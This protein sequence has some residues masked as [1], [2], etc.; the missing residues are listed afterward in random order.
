M[1]VFVWACGLMFWVCFDIISPWH[2][3]SLSQIR[4]IVK[5]SVYSPDTW[6]NCNPTILLFIV[7]KNTTYPQRPQI[8]HAWKSYYMLLCGNKLSFCY[9]MFRAHEN[10]NFSVS[11]LHKIFFQR[12]GMKKSCKISN[13]KCFLLLQTWFSKTQTNRISKKLMMLER[14]KRLPLN[15]YGVTPISIN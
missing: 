1:C 12:D 4:K 8:P 14:K 9:P 11:A 7:Y 2:F 5:L 6:P 10:L 3:R 13:S 15:I